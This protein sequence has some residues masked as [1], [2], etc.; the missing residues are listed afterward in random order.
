MKT[1]IVLFLTLFAFL[2]P[3]AQVFQDS[4]IYGLNFANGDLRFAT[5]D[6]STGTVNIVNNNPTSADQF[7][8]GV[9]DLDPISGNY[10]YIRDGRVYTVDRIT[11]NV[12]Q[13]PLITCATQPIH[14]VV[15]IT[16]I[17]YDFQ[18]ATL[19]GLHH[20]GS[21]LRFA[22]VDV[23]TGVMT[24][25]SPGVISQDIYMSGVSDIDP[26]NDRYFYIRDNRILTVDL[27]TGTLVSDF[28]IANPN[29]A[30]A[31]ITNIAY[32]YI[33]NEIYGLNFVSGVFPANGE[34]RLA[35]V[36][37]ATG[38]LTIISPNSISPDHFSSG[39]ADINPF[40]NLYT[41]VRGIGSNQQLISV[42]LST[43]LPVFSPSVTNPNN[44]VSPITNIAYRKQ[45]DFLPQP[46]A[47]F[48][49]HSSGL[50]VDFQNISR[51]GR[52]FEWDFGDGM[53]HTDK[54]P[55]RVY[56]AP[57][58]YT[59]T[60]RVDNGEGQDTIVQVLDLNGVANGA[61]PGDGSEILRVFPNPAVG[62]FR[63]Q[64][65]AGGLRIL[66]MQGRTVYEMEV[67]NSEVLDIQ[68][69][70]WPA[71]VYFIESAG[72]SGMQVQKLLLR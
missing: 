1:P 43:G 49:T 31:P 10:F 26:Y 13:S 25:L 42:D 22:K 8:S 55:S 69:N 47:A 46:A 34:L 16:N 68:G 41:Y 15:P 30:A 24:I 20:L 53:T 28:P 48:H 51:F 70:G 60:L 36:D 67:E 63:V 27:N 3:R 14:P 4:T 6:I 17:A 5:A 56:A 45:V 64:A 21:E 39:V 12:L 33:T 65:P 29:G 11:G 52:A 62:Q 18:T 7:A 66:D 54:H 2:A 72:P 32:N 58:I 19:Y 40:A 71:G 44:A 23:G 59:V 9:S 38:Q 37:P 35:S 50:A 61:E 57:G